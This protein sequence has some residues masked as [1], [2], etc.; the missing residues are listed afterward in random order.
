LHGGEIIDQR[1][2]S[3]QIIS[4]G[5]LLLLLTAGYSEEAAVVKS[6]GGER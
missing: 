4:F 1:T 5:L 6:H 2:I 3:F